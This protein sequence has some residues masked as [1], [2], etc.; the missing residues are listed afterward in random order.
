MRYFWVMGY[1]ATGKKTF[2]QR[3]D[4]EAQ[5]RERFGVPEGFVVRGPGFHGQERQV[6]WATE[7]V[8]INAPAV[9]IKW[10]SVC[11]K[12]PE[13]LLDLR[14]DA[15]HHLF[16]LKRPPQQIHRDLVK[17]DGKSDSSIEQIGAWIEATIKEC[18]D[19]S[20]QGFKLTVIDSTQYQ[21]RVADSKS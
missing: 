13:K 10:Q 15:E 17:R 3:L 20:K 2:L 7:L 12:E 21:Y 14:P 1:S 8:D 16:F 4:G 11:G 18:R 5:L 9:M 19:R 6:T